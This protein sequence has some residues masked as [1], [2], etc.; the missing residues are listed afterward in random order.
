MF[1]LVILFTK[2]IRFKVPMIG[3][4]SGSSGMNKLEQIIFGLAL[5]VGSFRCVISCCFTL[6]FFD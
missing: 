3:E 4:N 5:G 6:L 2:V 1:D